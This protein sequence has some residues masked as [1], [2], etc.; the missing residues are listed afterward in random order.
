MNDWD[1]YISE[2]I[3]IIFFLILFIYINLF[4]YSFFFSGYGR[5]ILAILSFYYMRTSP[6]LAAGSYILSGFLD[7]FDGHAARLL[8]QGKLH[9]R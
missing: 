1:L 8:N 7:A 6:G 5:I 4:I 2:M 9:Y 3:V